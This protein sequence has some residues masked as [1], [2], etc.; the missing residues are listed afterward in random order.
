VAA[1]SARAAV[2]DAGD[3]RST[4]AAGVAHFEAALRQGLNEAGFVEGQNV[5][6]WPYLMIARACANK[7]LS[8]SDLSGKG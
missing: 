7:P 4:T 1:R 3:V 8:T 6:V 5:A 2:G